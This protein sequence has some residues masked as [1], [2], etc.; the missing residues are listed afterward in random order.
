[1]ITDKSQMDPLISNPTSNEFFNSISHL[2]GTILSLAGMIV[3][4]VFS[5]LDSK[6]LHL[7]AFAIYGTTLFLS[8]LASTILHFNLLFNRYIRTLGILDHCAIYLLIA[9]TYTPYCLVL[10][11]GW[12]GWTIFGVIWSIAIFNITIKSIFFE[13]IP[14][15][16]S[17]ASYIMMG[18]MIVFV[19]YYIY[20]LLPA[21]ALIIL[22]SGGFCYT[23]GAVIFTRNRPDPWPPYFGSHEIWHLMVILGN[24]AMFLVQILY[25]LPHHVG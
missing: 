20:L 19:V 18:W 17:T 8:M 3:L 1:M 11:N 12:I 2:I 4:I 15:F 5:A 13:K 25:I 22:F 16:L 6:W 23:V 10:L 14:G 24:L 7:V 9:G 21:S